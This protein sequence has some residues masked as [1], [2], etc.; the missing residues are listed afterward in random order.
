MSDRTEIPAWVSNPGV[1]GIDKAWKQSAPDSISWVVA[2]PDPQ[3]LD[4]TDACRS[5]AFVN[6][7]SRNRAACQRQFLSR[8]EQSKKELKPV[9]FECPAQKQAIVFPVQQKGH[10]LGYWA[11]CHREKMPDP[12]Q[13]SLTR[14]ALVSIGRELEKTD[15]LKTLS[16]TLQ[17]RCA[18]LATVHTVHRLISSMLNTEELIPRVARLSCQV[19]R[20]Q[21]CSVWLTDHDN[22]RMV[23][24]AEIRLERGRFIPARVLRV[25]TGVIGRVA[26]SCKSH[27]EGRQ[28]AVPLMEEECIG[29]ICLERNRTSKPFT[30]LDHE[31]LTTLAEQAVVA[32]RNAQLYETQERVTWGTIRSLSAIMDEMDGDAGHLPSTQV[33]ADVALAI[34]RQMRLPEAQQRALHYAAMLHNAGRLGIP[35]EILRK[36]GSLTHH[37]L[38]QV[39][40]HPV[41]MVHLLAPLEMLEPAVPIILHHH[42]RYDGTGYP[43]GL[44]KEAIPLG[45][46]ILAVANALEAMIS[47][48]PYRP[49]MS[50]SQ[51]AAEIRLHAKSQF[52][53]EVVDAFLALVKE[54]VLER[55]LADSAA[56]PQ[57]PAV[58]Q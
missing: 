41:R 34:A 55:T 46:R 50:L 39:R 45:A 13:V 22:Q 52:D 56:Q 19:L 51:A 1:E 48:R 21:A 31:I 6:Q 36:S 29:V 10:L 38:E 40:S 4:Y 5:C 58:R 25:G 15:E 16:E 7:S 28:I 26:A 2:H 17:P 20:A 47:D 43:K 12:G 8:F 30:V 18:A 24:K 32:I 57:L 35:A 3:R 49:A 33:L 11:V 44:K 53:P 42:E 27:L 14:S 54:G 37:E 23:P 9:S